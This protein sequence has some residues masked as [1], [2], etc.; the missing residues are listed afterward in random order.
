MTLCFSFIACE[1]VAT[2]SDDKTCDGRGRCSCLDNVIGDKC[3]ICKDGYHNIE[4]GC[5]R[6]FI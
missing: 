5:I 4:E 3:D 6:K 1:C 2:G